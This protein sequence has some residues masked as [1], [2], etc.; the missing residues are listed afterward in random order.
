[1]DY[2]FYDCTNLAFIYCYSHDWATM[3]TNLAT[4]SY[5]FEN[6][7]SVVGDNG[8]AYSED[9]AKDV[10]MAH[11]DEEGNPGYFR[12]SPMTQI[13]GALNEGT[14][15]IYYD[16][17]IVAN[18]GITPN[19][20]YEIT[21]DE[22]SMAAKVTKVVFDETVKNAKPVT[23]KEWFYGFSKLTEIE[24]LDYLNLSNTENTS[25]MFGACTGIKEL[26]LSMWDM[27]SA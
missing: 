10:T 2:M 24:H 21:S 22:E 12:I 7:S 14:L 1:M 18:S 19:D 27:S 5:M 6:C 16:P 4:S 26:N 13:Y 3:A 11:F 9:K 8:T 17:Y 23:T 25:L 15:T 20:W